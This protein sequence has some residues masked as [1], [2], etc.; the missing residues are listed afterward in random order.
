MKRLLIALIVFIIFIIGIFFYNYKTATV[1]CWWGVL[2][3][4][5]SYVAFEEDNSTQISS[6]DKDYIYVKEEPVHIKIAILEWFKEKF[7]KEL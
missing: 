7:R 5:L 6:A 1:E 3:P 2:Y 4:N